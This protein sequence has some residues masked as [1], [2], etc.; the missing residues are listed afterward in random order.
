MFKNGSWPMDDQRK[1]RMKAGVAGLCAALIVSLSACGRAGDSTQANAGTAPPPPPGASFSTNFNSTENPISASG[2]WINGKVVGLD[3][4]NAQSVPGEA[5]GAAFATGY[6]DDIAVLNITFTANQY[7]QGTVHRLPGYSP[8]VNHEIELLLRFQIT[9][10]NARGYEVLWAHQG[11]MAIVRWNG[12]LGNYTPLVDNLVIGQAVDG[13]VLRA[14]ITGSVIK[15]YK[16]GSLVAT[17]PSD[18]TW[19]TG[20]PGIGFWPKPGAT[21][22]SYG[23]KNFQAGSL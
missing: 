13:D 14:E 3:W 23:W 10:N 6:D 18:T 7:A 4:N 17:S 5:Y 9:A 20:Q 21:L 22:K 16:N 12:P 19:T 8:G 1:R 15:V 11:N 2:Q